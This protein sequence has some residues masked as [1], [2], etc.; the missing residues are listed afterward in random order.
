MKTRNVF[1]IRRIGLKSWDGEQTP[2]RIHKIQRPA[3]QAPLQNLK[4]TRVNPCLVFPI[5][6]LKMR[7]GMVQ[8]I[9]L[10]TIP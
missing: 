3:R 6:G 9:H 4:I 7:R 8:P 10:N 5:K 2:D 1:L